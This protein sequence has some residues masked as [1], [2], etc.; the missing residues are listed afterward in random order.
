MFIITLHE[1]SEDLEEVAAF[2]AADEAERDA[3]LDRTE[4]AWPNLVSYSRRADDP[5][6]IPA[7]K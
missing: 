2:V 1:N 6:G 3:L 4:V 7:P 5:A